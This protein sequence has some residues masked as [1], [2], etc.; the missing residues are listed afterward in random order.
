MEL[1]PLTAA[2]SHR[3]AP[4]ER[5]TIRATVEHPWICRLVHLADITAIS[6][7]ADWASLDETTHRVK[8]WQ[9]SQRDLC[10][11]LEFV[12][13]NPEPPFVGPRRS[14]SSKVCSIL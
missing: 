11:E 2:C 4:T 12:P 7:A 10:V 5:W 13:A 14:N 3:V 1:P 6:P 9:A 8:A